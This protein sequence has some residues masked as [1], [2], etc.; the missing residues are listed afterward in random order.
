MSRQVLNILVLVVVGCLVAP[1]APGAAPRKPR[2]PLPLEADLKIEWAADWDA[3]YK[4]N[5][6]RWRKELAPLRGE[7]YHRLQVRSVQLYKALMEKYPKDAARCDTA[8][9]GIGTALYEAGMVAQGNEHVRAW[10][11]DSP[12]NVDRAA[13]ALAKILDKSN[14][15][16]YWQ[17]PYGERWVEYAS[18][19]LIELNLAGSLSDNHPSHILALQARALLRKG[20]RRPMEAYDALARLEAINGRDNFVRAE[21]AAVFASLGRAEDAMGLYHELSDRNVDAGGAMRDVAGFM[22]AQSAPNFPRKA[23]LEARCDQIASRSAKEQVEMIL[24]VLADDSEGSAMLPVGERQMTSIWRW[25]DQEL[26]A[27][28][29]DMAS[30]RTAMEQ[31]ALAEIAALPAGDLSPGQAG[32]DAGDAH[33]Q[34]VMALYR[35]FPFSISAHRLML[36][37]AQRQVRAGRAD[38]A[39]RM[40]EDVLQHS[41]DQAVRRQAQSGFLLA[42]THGRPSS[43]A[44]SA[45]L[46]AVPA[47]VTLELGGKSISARQLRDQLQAS[48]RPVAEVATIA[49]PGKT[50]ILNVPPTYLWPVELMVSAQQRWLSGR[51]FAGQIVEVAGDQLGQA[52]S[53]MKIKPDGHAL[54]LAGPNLLAMYAG[55]LDKPLWTA[56]PRQFAGLLNSTESAGQA[57][58]Y[59]VIPGQFQPAV[60]EGKVFTRWKQ[61]PFGRFFRCIAAFDAATGSMIWNSRDQDEL[62]EF[63]PMGD[64]VVHQGRLYVVVGQKGLGTMLPLTLVCVDATNG[65]VLWKSRL[66]TQLAALPVVGAGHMDLARYGNAVTVQD[67]AVF[68][69][70]NMGFVVRCDARDGLVEWVRTYGRARIIAEWASLFSSRL[71]SAPIVSGDKVIFMPRDCHGVFALDAVSGKPAWDNPVV[72]SAEIVGV[73]AGVLVLRDLQQVAALETSSGKVIWTRRFDQRILPGAMLDGPNVVLASTLPQSDETAAPRAAVLRLRLADGNLV[74]QTDLDL[75]SPLIAIARSSGQVACVTAS[76]VC[77]QEEIGRPLNA[78]A[79]PNGLALPVRQSWTLARQGAT[80]IVPPSHARMDGKVL[81]MSHTTLECVSATAKGQVDWRL[82][83]RPAAQLAWGDKAIYVIYDREVMAIDAAS[84]K[85]LWETP[86]DFSIRQS[87]L[88]GRTLVLGAFAPVREPLDRT[89]AAID[90]ATGKLLWQ[91]NFDGLSGS[92]IH[93]TFHSIAWDGT[94]I[95]LLSDRLPPYGHCDAVISPKDG[96]VVKV[97]TVP[98]TAAPLA[99]MVA[100]TEGWG[101]GFGARRELIVFDLAK[102]EQPSIRNLDTRGLSLD[103]FEIDGLYMIIRAL[104]ERGNKPVTIILKKDDPNYLV[105]LPGGAIIRSGQCIDLSEDRPGVIDLARKDAKA[106]AIDEDAGDFGQ[107]RELMDLWQTGGKM[108]TLTGVKRHVAGPWYGPSNLRL[109]VFDASGK[110]QARQT[111]LDASFDRATSGIANSICATSSGAVVGDVLLIADNSGLHAYIGDASAIAAPAEA[112]Y[113]AQAITLDGSIDDWKDI[114]PVKVRTSGAEALVYLANDGGTVY[115]AVTVDVTRVPRRVGGGAG[116]G[117]GLLEV[118]VQSGVSKFMRS[119]ISVLGDGQVRVERL[120]EGGDWDCTAVVRHDAA[121]GRMVYEIAMPRGL[122]N[123]RPPLKLTSSAISV[124]MWADGLE[125]DAKPLM[126]WRSAVKLQEPPKKP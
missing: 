1:D 44:V 82:V 41:N 21:L 97:V 84:G 34:Q 126:L 71:G 83:L 15:G 111:I 77:G 96:Q 109:D 38:A 98:K 51:G 76:S 91:T 108:L 58:A 112:V 14:W 66:G 124:A 88:C 26:L 2:R 99:G 117:G 85:P 47:D 52:A 73:Q 121:A 5:M 90:I 68:V 103:G 80:M 31:Q 94:N 122:F 113:Q 79:Q 20:Q 45:C 25:V 61:E 6:D 78:S 101:F 40:F 16:A 57:T 119:G 123:V 102:I 105:R 87:R 39:A 46:A 60:A 11:E 18:D 3:T 4:S 10:I 27:R 28:G 95:H 104:D 125:H 69:S 32:R 13:K 8:M 74:D 106:L 48:T 19:N 70:T 24:S 35:K 114:Q 22:A 37:A 63:W 29:K 115:M 72:T 86:V 33:D 81:L 7:N 67:G 49:Q 12:G 42:L 30:L 120:P 75:K 100:T 107:A 93:N 89:T 36:D 43:A 64:P 118:N 62:D 50:A 54:V 17:Y 65:S 116:G 59:P 53:A 9:E 92:S 110:H 56:S 23:A 55:G